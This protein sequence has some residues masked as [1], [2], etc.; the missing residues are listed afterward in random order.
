M[1]NCH[2]LCQVS[3]ELDH[4]SAD[5]GYLLVEELQFLQPRYGLETCLS[6]L[7]GPRM[8]NRAAALHVKPRPFP[9]P[10]HFH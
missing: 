1:H 4:L 8:F 7:H 2:G 5:H 10:E 6:Q 3:S 9:L